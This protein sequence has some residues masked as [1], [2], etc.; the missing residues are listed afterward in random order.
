[1]SFSVR[2]AAALASIVAVAGAC[3][4]SVTTQLGEGGSDGGLPPQCQV[5]TSDKPPYQLSFNFRNMSGE[6]RFLRQGCNLS[7][8]ITSCT[9]G[10][11]KP[12]SPSVSCSMDCAAPPENGCIVCSCMVT[13][14]EISPNSTYPVAWDGIHYT[15]MTNSAGCPCHD[16]HVA[17]A[18]KYRVVIPVYGSEAA[19]LDDQPLREAV[20]DFELPTPGGIVEVPL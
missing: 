12:L 16:D 2:A 14:I 3:G 18:G 1:M 8:H 13:G 10:Y 7:Y 17:P 6:T 4:G 5:S 19:A 11:Q 15:D 9:D 20:V